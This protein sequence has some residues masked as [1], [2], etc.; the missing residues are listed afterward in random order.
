MPQEASLDLSP[1]SGMNQEW[2]CIIRQSGMALYLIFLTFESEWS[3]HSLESTIDNRLRCIDG[4]LGIIKLI[5]K[6]P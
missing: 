1:F 5:P 4:N 6:E 3:E 2:D